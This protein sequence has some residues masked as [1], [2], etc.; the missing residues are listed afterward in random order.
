MVGK[1]VV[2]K[3]GYTHDD[4]GDDDDDDDDDD[5]EEDNDEH[6]NENHDHGQNTCSTGEVRARDASDPQSD[7]DHDHNSHPRVRESG[8]SQV[9]FC[10]PFTAYR[11]P[12]YTTN[13][14]WSLLYTDLHVLP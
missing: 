3:R 12:V 14:T 11:V 7:R 8:L 6:D 10:C 9:V 5:E 2:G 13:Q 1:R 4:D